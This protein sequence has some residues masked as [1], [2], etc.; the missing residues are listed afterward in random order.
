MPVDATRPAM[1]VRPAARPPEEP[2]AAMTSGLP[3][4]A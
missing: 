4:T 2:V 1:I 3:P